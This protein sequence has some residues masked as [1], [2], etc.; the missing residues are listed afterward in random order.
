MARRPTF[1]VSHP[2]PRLIFDKVY[3]KLTLSA[4]EGAGELLNDKSANGKDPNVVA[5]AKNTLLP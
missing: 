2:R 5:F 3:A 4:R 1:Q